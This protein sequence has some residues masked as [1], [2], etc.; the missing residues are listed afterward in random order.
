MEKLP[1]MSLI[2]VIQNMSG[3]AP[4]S[5]YRY[6]VLVGDGTIAGSRILAAGELVGH[7]RSDGW[8]KLVQLLLDDEAKR[9]D[10][11]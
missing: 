8:P 3:L 11:E 4:I 1:V 9:P 7:A 10:R 6:Q 2:V 5:N